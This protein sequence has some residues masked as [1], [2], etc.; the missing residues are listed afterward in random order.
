MDWPG[1][2]FHGARRREGFLSR[3]R[4]KGLETFQS[5]TELFSVSPLRLD[6]LLA[7]F[8]GIASKRFALL[9]LAA[10]SP[11]FPRCRVPWRIHCVLP[12]DCA[13]LEEMTDECGSLMGCREDP[14]S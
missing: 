14:E 2:C 9:L 1:L 11:R 13:V 10:L 4:R 12:Q 3:R 6:I 7:S 8:F 5:P